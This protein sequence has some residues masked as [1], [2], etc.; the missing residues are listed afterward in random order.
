MKHNLAKVGSVSFLAIFA[1]VSLYLQTKKAPW[2]DEC[3]TYYGILHDSFSEFTD[4][5]LSGINFSPPLYFFINWCLQLIYPLSIEIL[6]VESIIWLLAGCLLCF[7]TCRKAFGELPAC[8]AL[9]VVLSQSDSLAE[10]SLEAR[11]YTMF[12]ACGA[13]VLFQTHT[14]ES[15]KNSRHRNWLLFLAHLSL[16]LTHYMGVVFSV[17]VGMAHILCHLEKPLWK[18]IPRALSICWAITIPVYLFLFGKQTSHL[19]TWPKPNDLST[20]LDIYNSSFLVLTLGFL[21]FLLTLI[22]SPNKN[23]TKDSRDAHQTNTVFWAA[24][25]WLTIPLGIWL[26]SHFSPLN[27]FKD[28]Y[29]IPKEAGLFVFLAF[30]IRVILSKTNF[31]SSGNPATIPL[32]AIFLLCVGILSVRSKRALFALHPSHNYHHSLIT[33]DTLFVGKDAVIFPSDPSYFPNSIRHKKKSFLKVPNDE[34]KAIYLSFSPRINLTCE[35]TINGS[36]VLFFDPE[37]HNEPPQGSD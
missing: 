23:R 13:W 16:C 14:W 33:P 11:H 1:S 34:M 35:Q 22:N 27:L 17:F 12:F 21:L 6:R 10:Q 29:F 25:F 36:S 9:F 19:N 28:R 24:T 31:N 5:I 18:R 32:T 3:Y 26:L 15:S 4:S 20:L 7:A 8:I 30:A 37:S 2:V